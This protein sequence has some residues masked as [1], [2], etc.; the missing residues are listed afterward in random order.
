MNSLHIIVLFLFVAGIAGALGAVAMN[1]FMRAVSSGRGR[2]INMVE[3]LASYFTG[4]L[5]NALK[6]GT[7]IHLSAGVLFGYIYTVIIM[8]VGIGGFVPVL[9]M[10]AGL[11]LVHGLLVSY[12][13]MFYVAERHPIEK[14]RQATFEVGALH[15]VG[16]VIYGVVVGIVIG[17]F[18]QLISS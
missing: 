4:S 12:G 17:L 7:I 5:D 8:A 18:P 16:H 13:L 1:G 3:A 2:S 15:L 11:G 6:V 10:A 9:F 14:Y